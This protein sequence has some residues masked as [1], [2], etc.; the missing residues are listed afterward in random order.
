MSEKLH[1]QIKNAIDQF[2]NFLPLFDNTIRTVERKFPLWLPPEIRC[3]I[4]KFLPIS[5]AGTLAFPYLV[6]Q[7]LFLYN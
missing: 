6:H 5:C 1:K 4:V 3:E 7:V 2:Q